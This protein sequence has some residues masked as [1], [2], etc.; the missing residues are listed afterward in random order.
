ML[1]IGLRVAAIKAKR[2]ALAL[3]TS[4]QREKEKV[5][6]EKMMQQRTGG[7]GGGMMGGMGGGMM[8]GSHGGSPQAEPKKDKGPAEEHRH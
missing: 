2:E 4:E 6:H 1:E 3:L 7:M 8:G 5:E